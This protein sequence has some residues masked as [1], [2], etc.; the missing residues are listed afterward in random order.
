MDLG[1]GNPYRLQLFVRP[2]ARSKEHRPLNHTQGGLHS[3][4][5]I[6]GLDLIQ[7]PVS[8]PPTVT[9]S[10]DIKLA[11]QLRRRF[12]H[13]SFTHGFHW[14]SRT[15]NCTGRPQKSWDQAEALS[16]HQ[17]W[18]CRLAQYLPRRKDATDHPYFTRREEAQ[19]LRVE[20]HP[21]PCPPPTRSEG[22]GGTSTG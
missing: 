9:P 10:A 14:R 5:T 19:E 3:F 2:R 13:A 15:R 16:C 21:P 1:R 12:L 8:D 7:L 20:M 22:S 18:H 4:H 17:N 6:S 11:S